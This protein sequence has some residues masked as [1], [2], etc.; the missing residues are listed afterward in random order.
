MCARRWRWQGRKPRH[1]APSRPPPPPSHK[2]HLTRHTSARLH[3]P[4]NCLKQGRLRQLLRP[5]RS[6]ARE[7]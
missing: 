2:S 7:V 6:A 1:A 3:Q 4:T 5:G